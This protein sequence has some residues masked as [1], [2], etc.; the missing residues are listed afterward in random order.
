MTIRSKGRQAGAILIAI[1]VTIAVVA[2][3]DLDRVQAELS[4]ISRGA[5]AIATMLYLPSWVLRGQRWRG[6]ARDLG[7]ELPLRA[8]C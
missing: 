3:L 6:I 2:S 1:G 8:T 5:L 7:D 4:H